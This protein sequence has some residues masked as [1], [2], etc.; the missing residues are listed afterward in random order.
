M[1]SRFPLALRIILGVLKKLIITLININSVGCVEG[2]GIVA[3]FAPRGEI[4]RQTPSPQERHKRLKQPSGEHTN[5]IKVLMMSIGDDD[6]VVGELESS[7]RS[8]VE[9]N[10][11]F[12]MSN[13]PFGLNS[14][15]IKVAFASEQNCQISMNISFE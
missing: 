14:V 1:A 13:D 3:L 12:S 9:P 4:L 8:G 6:V 5:S 15:P 7:R 11:R 10:I 2:K